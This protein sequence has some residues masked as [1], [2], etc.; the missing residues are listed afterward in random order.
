MGAMI[1]CGNLK[2]GT[3]KSTVAVNLASVLGRRGWRTGLADLDPQGT[4]VGW[5]ACGRLPIDVFG[6]PIDDAGFDQAWSERVVTIERR[7]EVLVVDLP[8]LR[9]APLAAITLLCDLLLIPVTPS[10][11]D[12]AATAA[13]L[14]VVQWAR[15]CRPDG[16]PRGLLVPNRVDLDAHYDDATRVAIESLGGTWTPPLSR[17]TNFANAFAAGRWVG[18]HVPGSETER[19]V[20]ALADAVVQHL[21]LPLPESAESPDLARL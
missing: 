8:P 13:A 3:G 1:A 7:F 18:D 6:I 4:A 21:G 12:A 14:A 17:S 20:E 11:V 9:R 2:G 15:D 10:A 16:W 19:E 5:A